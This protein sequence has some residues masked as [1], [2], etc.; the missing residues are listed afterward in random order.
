M[1]LG[2]TVRDFRDKVGFGEDLYLSST[3]RES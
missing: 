1:S 3:A 2:D